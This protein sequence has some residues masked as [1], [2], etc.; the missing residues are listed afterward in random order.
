MMQTILKDIEL[1][2]GAQHSCV[3]QQGKVLASTF[4]DTQ[5]D[6]LSGLGKVLSQ[7]FAGTDAL[8]QQYRETHI[9]LA[10][11]LLLGYQLD[12]SCVLAVLTEKNSNIALIKTAVRSSSDKLIALINQNAPL[13]GGTFVTDSSNSKPLDDA[14]VEAELESLQAMLAEYIGPAARIVFARARASWEASGSSVANLPHLW[15]SLANFID[16]EQKRTDFLRRANA[17]LPNG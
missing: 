14:A 16:N 12:S 4:P 13:M 15:Q 17:S 3:I 2:G 7:I 9:E 8:Q 1:L 11:K 10:E 5:K 6:S